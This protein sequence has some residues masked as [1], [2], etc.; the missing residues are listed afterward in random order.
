[1]RVNNK[2]L[3]GFIEAAI[4][5]HI[6]HSRIDPEIIDYCIQQGEDD[7]LV[8][9]SYKGTE[10]EDDAFSVYFSLTM[11]MPINEWINKINNALD[12]F[13]SL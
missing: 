11:E 5:G 8:T 7:T 10:G 1:M 6:E 12:Q 13:E 3:E 4:L 9:F 2:Y